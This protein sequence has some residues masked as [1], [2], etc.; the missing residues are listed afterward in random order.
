MYLI[1]VNALRNLCKIK[2]KNFR[3]WHFKTFTREETTTYKELY[4]KH[5]E[6]IG[7]EQPFVEWFSQYYILKIQ[8][9]KEQRTWDSPEGKSITSKHPEAGNII[10]GGIEVVSF[11]KMDS[12]NTNEELNTIIKQNNYSHLHLQILASHLSQIEEKWNPRDKVKE[13]VENEK[14]KPVVIKPPIIPKGFNTNTLL[15]ENFIEKLT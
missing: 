13:E 5:L 6:I 14:I 12:K 9:S 1:E 11:V 10:Y 2:I 3:I 15:N 7:Y 4:Y 8:V